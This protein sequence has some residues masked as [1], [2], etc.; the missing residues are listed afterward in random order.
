MPTLAEAQQDL[1][2][3]KVELSAME[4]IQRNSF[5]LS[6]RDDVDNTYYANI[7][8]KVSKDID[9]GKGV[10]LKIEEVIRLLTDNT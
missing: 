9:R 8:F 4:S 3:I 10:K 7:N 2:D 6:S 1:R 5:F